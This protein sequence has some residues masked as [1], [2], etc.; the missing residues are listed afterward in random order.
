ML[1][2]ITLKEIQTITFDT[3]KLPVLVDLSISVGCSYFNPLDFIH[4]KA[5]EDH[6]GM[7]YNPYSD[8]WSYL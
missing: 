4:S 7:I 2:T 3:S 6:E 1:Q 5:E 8:K